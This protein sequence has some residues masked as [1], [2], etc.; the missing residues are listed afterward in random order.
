M[1]GTKLPR[2]IYLLNQTDLAARACLDMNLRDLKLT[3][4][5]YTILTI[6]R[7]RPGISS[8]QLSR[9]FF[10]SP[11]TMNEIVSGMEKRGLLRRETSDQNKRVLVIHLTEEGADLLAQGDT[12]ADR[13]EELAFEAL[14]PEELNALRGLLRR[15]AQHHRDTGLGKTK[16]T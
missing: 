11:Q 1:T 9:R 14:N 10:V 16:I 12:L 15:V 2:T 7:A 13:V 8:A 6:I 5:Q 4:L 3:G